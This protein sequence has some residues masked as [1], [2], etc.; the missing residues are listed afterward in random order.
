MSKDSAA[1]IVRLADQISEM[2]IRGGL[3]G[4]VMI[5]IGD[6]PDV[7]GW[8]VQCAGDLNGLEVVGVLAS[9]L[10]A[11]SSGLVNP[12]DPTAGEADDR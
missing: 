9:S 6:A 12:I 5:V 8:K 7:P 4:A 2:A 1:A 3:R 11:L 10:I